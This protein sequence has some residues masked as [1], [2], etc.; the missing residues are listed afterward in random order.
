MTTEMPSTSN[1]EQEQLAAIR[2]EIDAIDV[3]IQNLISARALCA[4]K[5]A[6]IKTQGGQVE[7]IF[8]RPEREAQVLRDV[9]RRNKSLISDDDMA[10]LFREIMS[11]CLALE[12][13]LK[14]AY[15]G[16]EGSYSHACVIK[17]FGSF[18]HPYAVSSIEEVFDAVEQGVAQY[19]LV[20]VENSS[21]GVVKQTQNKLL[22]TQLQVTSEVDLAIHHNL[23]SNQTSMDGIKK[24]VAHSQALGQCASWLKN[25]LPQVVLESVAS[26]ALAAQMAQ[27]DASVAAIASEQAAQLYGL[28]ILETH[29]EDFKDNTTKFWVLGHEKTA[30]SGEDKTAMIVSVANKAGAL[31]AIMN[32]FA[33]RNINMTRII[34]VP[35]HEIAS[36]SKW[37]YWFFIDIE[38]HQ[39]QQA[40]HEAI[41]DVQAHSAYC[42]LL[43]SFPVSPLQ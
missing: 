33:A 6:D 1:S 4:Q 20:P 23:L 12:Q 18:A 14:V 16:P 13:P 42:K 29:I 19:G 11:V 30:P 5:V 43:G 8:Y 34:S 21:E 2:Q 39:A 35:S 25:N 36:S 38:G 9:K 10:R 26:N 24:V 22:S 40:V 7:T 31:L 41:Q 37:A 15:L 17:Q 28:Q 3:Q 27:A 32:S